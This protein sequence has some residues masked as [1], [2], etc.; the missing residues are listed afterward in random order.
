MSLDCPPTELLLRLSEP[1]LFDDPEEAREVAARAADCPDCQAILTQLEVELTPPPLPFD[2]Q[3]LLPELRSLLAERAAPAPAPQLEVRLLCGYCRDGL[4]TSEALYCASCL[5]PHHGECYAEHGRC[6]APG[7]ESHAVVGARELPPP[8]RKPRRLWSAALG[9]IGLVA[10]G[11]VAAFGPRGLLPRGDEAPAAALA[12]ASPVAASPLA[13]SPAVSPATTPGK[14]GGLTLETYAV[15][16]LVKTFRAPRPAWEERYRRRLASQTVTLNFPETPLSDVVTFL[17]DIT[18]LNLTLGK[19]LNLEQ[20]VSLRIRDTLLEDALD[21]IAEQGQIRWSLIHGTVYLQPVLSG[22]QVSQPVSWPL[23]DAPTPAEGAELLAALTKATA[24]DLGAEAWREPARAEVRGGRLHVTQTAAGHRAV[25]AFLASRRLAPPPAALAG[26]WFAPRPPEGA[27]PAVVRARLHAQELLSEVSLNTAGSVQD[28]LAALRTS[29][30]TPIRVDPSASALVA[31]T[32]V[33]L[34]LRAVTRRDA[35]NLICAAAPSLVWEVDRHGVLLRPAQAQP[36][37][38]RLRRAAQRA[39]DRNANSDLRQALQSQVTLNLQASPGDEAIDFLRDIS[40]LNFVVTREARDA[41]AQEV[42]YV[43]AKVAISEALEQILTPLKLGTHLSQGVIRIVPL[44]RASEGAALDARRR[45]LLDR[46]VS[47]GDLRGLGIYALAAALEQA[48]ELDVHLDEGLLGARERVFLP[49]GATLGEV[50]ELLPRQAGLEP[51]LAWAPGLGRFVL[52]LRRGRGPDLRSCL[53]LV[54]K[55][56]PWETPPPPVA[57]GWGALQRALL[58]D[59][60]RLAAAKGEVLEDR[61][62]ETLGRTRAGLDLHACYFFLGNEA[63]QA[64]RRQTAGVTAALLRDLVS[65]GRSLRDAQ[66]VHAV[67]TRSSRQILASVEA[68]LEAGEITPAEAA[69]ARSSQVQSATTAAKEHA[70]YVARLESER[71]RLRERLRSVCL[72]PG[73]Q[74]RDAA[75]RARLAA[76]EAYAQV[77]PEGYR[78]A[79][80]RALAVDLKRC[81]L[82]EALVVDSNEGASLRHESIQASDRVVSLNGTPTPNSAALIAALGEALER[83]APGAQVEV[84]ATVQR[85]PQTLQLRL[86]LRR[87]PE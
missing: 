69:E 50:L 11:G 53:T 85:G 29:G 68:R 6:V 30:S 66:V 43:G 60:E 14:E 45:E 37:E 39:F 58:L 21:L 20:T 55:A 22:H 16:D 82:A 1:D 35:L 52:A 59:L 5:T 76:G 19:G 75:L 33:E 38:G 15:G 64:S 56:C 32:K 26:A 8:P 12:P 25:V 57:E 44:E 7:C 70:L 10:L 3:E 31:E 67:R 42:S 49:A 86:E 83:A 47:P 17:R 41:L 62:R 78:S 46:K 18:G 79:E 40:G 23:Q 36:L 27:P 74:E 4:R 72:L 34:S 84:D 71:A 51:G 81:G 13:A 63:G 24:K 87:P 2:P 80:K 48:C 9:A 73:W 54:S 77:F 28:A 65:K 61:L